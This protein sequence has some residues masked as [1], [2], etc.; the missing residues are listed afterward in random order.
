M[1]IFYDHLKSLVRNQAQ[2]DFKDDKS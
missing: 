2:K 1:R